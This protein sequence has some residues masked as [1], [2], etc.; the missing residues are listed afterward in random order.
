MLPTKTFSKILRVKL[1]I[2]NSHS[3]GHL[4][5]FDMFDVL[6]TAHVIR[7]NCRT[8]CWLCSSG[9]ELKN[10]S[11]VQRRKYDTIVNI[12]PYQVSS[13]S[14]MQNMIHGCTI[15][16]EVSE[17]YIPVYS[18]FRQ[19]YVT[20]SYCSWMQAITNL[21]THNCKIWTRTV[22]QNSSFIRFFLTKGKD[23][24]GGLG[25]LVVLTFC[26]ILSLTLFKRWNN[27]L[28]T[29]YFIEIGF[30][31]SFTIFNMPSTV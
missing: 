23:R 18:S 29:F 10:F 19:K 12:N 17:A 3:N 9:N 15:W 26:I 7:H 11:R 20:L 22:A 5:S 14:I 27:Y 28:S 21:R 6:I 2:Q 1:S 25:L 16:Q 30:G 13:K 31:A 4:T 24:E 8:F